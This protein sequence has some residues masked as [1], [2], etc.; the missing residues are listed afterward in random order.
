MRTKL[1]SVF[2]YM[3]LMTGSAF[4]S[5]GIIFLEEAI[6]RPTFFFLGK[7]LTGVVK[8]SI[9]GGCEE[10]KIAITSET[11]AFMDKKPVSLKSMSRTTAKPSVIFF[12]IK[13]KKATRLL[14]V[15]KR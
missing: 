6:E 13:T 10:I 12:D 7:N 14:W 15:S 1:I 8:G 11:L 2:L 9:C 4:A 5:N 3:C